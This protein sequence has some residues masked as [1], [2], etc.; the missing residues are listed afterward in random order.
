MSSH[1]N[2][3]G[4]NDGSSDDHQGGGKGKLFEIDIPVKKQSDI[5]FDAED[6]ERQKMAALH[7]NLNPDGDDDNEQVME[8]YYNDGAT[9]LFLALEDTD[10]RRALHI[11]QQKPIQSKIWVISTGTV[12]TTFGWSLWR[13]LPLHEACRRQAP[14][15]LISALLSVHPSAAEQTTQFGELPLHLA[16]ECG[17]PPEVVNL[18]VV[19][20][21]HG[22]MATDQSGRTPLEI[23]QDSEMLAMEDHQVVF[24]SLTRSQETYQT[25][26]E[27][28]QEEIK[29]IKVRHAAGLVAIR[30]QHDEDLQQ[31]QEQQEKLLAEVERLKTFVDDAKISNKKD[32]DQIQ[33]LTQAVSIEKTNL[34]QLQE[35]LN[36]EIAA[37]VQ[38]A[39][40]VAKLEQEVASKNKEI[41]ALKSQV[42]DLQG[43]LQRIAGWQQDVLARQINNT[44]ESMQ[45]MVEQFVGLVDL[46]SNQGQRM[47]SVLKSRN[48]TPPPPKPKQSSRKKDEKKESESALEPLDEDTLNNIAAAA[49]NALQF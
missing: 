11:I 14:A 16:V 37:G 10:W 36:V 13:R 6:Q 44:E 47:A 20:H 17:A 19:T 43:D 1:R 39:T 5:S 41:A 42:Q 2:K 4:K 24:E 34:A 48:I 27:E 26:L 23:L 7:G 49:S 32:L 46:L 28:H 18:L 40:R 8:V 22:I 33:Q 30:Q 35:Q 15:W 25:I 38:K 9:D 12:E 3:G 31:E 45:T 29:G 21:W